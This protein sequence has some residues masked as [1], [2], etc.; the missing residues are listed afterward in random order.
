[1]ATLPLPPTTEVQITRVVKALYDAA[2]GNLY[3]Q[4]FTQYAADNGGVVGVADG[5]LYEHRNKSNA[6]VAQLIVKNLGLAKVDESLGVADDPAKSAAKNAEAFLLWQFN[7]A[8]QTGA[9]RGQVLVEALNNLATLGSDEIFG[10]AAAYFNQSIEY[11]YLYSRD[12]AN[13]AINSTVDD[14]VIGEDGVVVQPGQT[15]TL[16]AALG[17][18]IVGTPGNDTINAVVSVGGVAGGQTLSLTDS[19]DGAG[20]HDTIN[21]LAAGGAN[22]VLSGTIRNVEVINLIADVVGTDTIA[23]A[24]DF[25]NFAGAER[26]NVHGDVVTE[27]S[28]LT[29]DNSVNFVAATANVE[30]NVADGASVANIVLTNVT[31]GL[32]LAVGEVAAGDLSTVNVSGS[33]AG[34]GAVTID[35]NA[36]TTS[37]TAPAAEDTLNLAL[38]TD[39][40]VTITSATLKTIDASASTG[41]LKIT[42]PATVET[43]IGGSG[44][45]TLT[46]STASK[47]I[48]G[49]AGNDTIT[50]GDVAGE[51]IIGGAGADVITLGTGSNAQTVV[52]NAGDSGV[53]LATADKISDFA[54][55]ED[56]LDFN[57]A[58][59]STDNFLDA[60][61][62][63]SFVDALTNAKTAFEA[64]AG[65]LQYFF[66]NAGGNGFL[67]VDRNLDGTVD[68]AIELTGVTTIVAADI[69]A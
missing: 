38:S 29:A 24:I 20:G 23:T 27:V 6:E 48:E 39:G 8:D 12:P 1:M 45:D 60:G 51:V 13:V 10:P 40:T 19:V 26:I 30:A 28:G 62:S 18:N 22:A 43:L 33:V 17:E 5:L 21:I 57:L 42:S 64:D 68:Q 55:G 44:D 16:T 49:G 35:L 36:S 31:S 15:F 65:T 59:G 50:A 34:A 58:A 7:V 54:T 11:A 46:G 66:S 37:G 61:P 56:F 4:A 2:P 63:S 52:I 3:L 25:G 67:F 53:T 14:P 69:I 9:T 32:T 47:L 41:G